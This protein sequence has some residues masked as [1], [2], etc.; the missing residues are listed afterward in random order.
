VHLGV[1]RGEF[2]SQSTQL[3]AIALAFY[4]FGLIGHSLLE[5]ISRAFYALHDTRTPV[6]IGVGSMV[7]NLLLSLLLRPYLGHAGLALA[8]TLATML[9]MVLLLWLL[10]RRLGSLEWPQL[11]ST[12]V[13][14][15]VAA[16]IMALPLQWAASYWTDGPAVLVGIMG[17]VIGAIIYL[18]AAL[19]L[20]MRE[21]QVVWQ[22]VRR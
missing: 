18:A 11:S 21:L 13:R 19:L 4:A 5:I 7:L 22:M 20:R 15:V 16:L 12:T 8:N 10:T 14:A 3:T 9:E 6:T 2:T 1:E 17:L